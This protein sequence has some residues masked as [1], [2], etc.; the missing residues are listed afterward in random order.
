M[1]FICIA[2]KLFKNA[3]DKTSLK[4]GTLRNLI[5]RELV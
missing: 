4:N 1:L 2:G 3:R 5:E